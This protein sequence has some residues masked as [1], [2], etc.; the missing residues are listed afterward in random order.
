MN[1]N[2]INKICQALSLS[3]LI[4]LSTLLNKS[5]SFNYPMGFLFRDASIMSVSIVKLTLKDCDEHFFYLPN[6]FSPKLS[7]PSHLN[8]RVCNVVK[9]AK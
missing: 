8:V 6:K 9:Y 2:H 7:M 3:I 5:L 1:L 4:D